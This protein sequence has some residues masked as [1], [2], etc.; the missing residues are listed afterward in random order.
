MEIIIA[1]LYL[2][3]IGMTLGFMIEV[4]AKPNV[5]TY[6]CVFLWPVIGLCLSALLVADLAINAWR[7][8]R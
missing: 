2:A 5:W 4:N 6:G 7:A 1:L 8:I 3:G